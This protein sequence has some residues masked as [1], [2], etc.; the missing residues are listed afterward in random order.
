[1]EKKVELIVNGE[2]NDIIN[3]IVDDWDDHFGDH[4]IS[5]F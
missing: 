3:I 5:T 1:M 2:T 4:D